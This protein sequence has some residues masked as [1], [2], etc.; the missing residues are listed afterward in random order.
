VPLH[1]CVPNR[2]ELG[3]WGS[4]WTP[5]ASTEGVTL[6]MLVMGICNVLVDLRMLPMR[7]VP[8]LPK[9]AHEVLAAVG[10]ILEHL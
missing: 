8:Q 2:S 6:S 3:S 9:K 5:G 4:G 7:D 10:L 1:P